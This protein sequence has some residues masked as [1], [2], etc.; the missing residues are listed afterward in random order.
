MRHINQVHYKGHTIKVW[1][2]KDGSRIVFRWGRRLDPPTP[3]RTNPPDRFFA[4]HYGWY[5]IESHSVKQIS[6]TLY[7]DKIGIQ[8]RL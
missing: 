6:M 5:A 7:P 1:C 8:M 3:A 4:W 2:T